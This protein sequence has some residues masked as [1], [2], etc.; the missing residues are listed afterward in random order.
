MDI[1]K[2]KSMGCVPPTVRELNLRKLKKQDKVIEV[3][4]VAKVA[5]SDYGKVLVLPGAVWA[6]LDS[7]TKE[8]YSYSPVSDT[9]SKYKRGKTFITYELDEAEKVLI[10]ISTRELK[11]IKNKEEGFVMANQNEN[12]QNEL[13]ALINEAGLDGLNVPEIGNDLG[14]QIDNMS[15][16]DGDSKEIDPEKA[17]EEAFKKE[18]AEKLSGVKQDLKEG[19]GA[20][21]FDNA[22][23][24]G[25]FNRELGGLYGF[26]VNT[27]PAV[28]IAK[29][30]E[31]LK[32]G[33]AYVVS[34]DAP[35]DIKTRAASTGEVPKEYRKTVTVL[36]VK[37][38]APTGIK[39]MVLKIPGGG[40]LTPNDIVKGDF[41][42]DK[43]NT[44]LKTIMVTKDEGLNFITTAFAGKIYDR[45]V[46]DGLKGIVVDSRIDKKKL[47]ETG[48]VVSRPYMKTL[49]KSKLFTE[50]NF[51]P[52]R[53]FKTINVTNPLTEKDAALA[54]L[55]AFY[56]LTKI[57]KKKTIPD[58]SILDV[59][60]KN[61][62]TETKEEVGVSIS[63]EYFKAGQ[64][65]NFFGDEPK[66]W[67][68][69][70]PLQDI[71]LPVRDTNI[72]G[73]EKPTYPWIQYS[74]IS[75][76][77]LKGN[78]AYLS[79]TAFGL[80]RYAPVR[81]LMGSVLTPLEI[82]AIAVKPR[83]GGNNNN[84]AVDTS[85]GFEGMFALLRKTAM[86]TLDTGKFVAASTPLDSPSLED[87]MSDARAR[88]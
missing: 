33:D 49:D 16:F 25:N 24:L 79:K 32:V 22:K 45:S 65:A 42:V 15:S 62:I 35:A 9:Y 46:T 75:S 84:S 20:D 83:E 47:Q 40:F 43:S 21:I 44:A 66:H 87:R 14:G 28:K 12:M 2:L 10:N 82:K 53:V 30:T 70:Q 31:P 37:Q 50:T 19:L 57:T 76:D 67:L 36:K 3:T 56:Q 34:D 58:L 18:M 7:K 6:G 73:K 55:S 68:T 86:Q 48:Q 77:A 5:P 38:S 60:Y 1:E 74:A 39:G 4:Q 72:E 64:P 29:K 85:L 81:E 8:I 11:S 26:V 71:D 13:D 69:G 27:E 23:E 54:S 78:E 17:K 52:I 51:F 63:S 88:R 61:R 41:T 59:K 80:A